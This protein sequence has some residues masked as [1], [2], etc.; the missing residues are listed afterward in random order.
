MASQKSSPPD[1]AIFDQKRLMVF[2]YRRGGEG[3]YLFLSLVRFMQSFKKKRSK[4]DFGKNI[5]GK[6][7]GGSV[8][9]KSGS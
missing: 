7:A 3:L 8:W 1:K 4:S 9:Y 6:Q 5:K 2:P